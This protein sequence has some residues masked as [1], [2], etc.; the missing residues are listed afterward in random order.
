[1]IE[2]EVHLTEAVLSDLPLRQFDF[3]MPFVLRNL[4][5]FDLELCA[6][7]R[8][9]VVR[10]VLGFYRAAAR[11][12]V[13]AP[14]FG[15]AAV[16][17]QRL[18]SAL[19]TDVRFHILAFHGLFVEPEEPDDPD[20]QPEFQRHGNPADGDIER[21]LAT[22]RRRVLRLLAQRRGVQLGA[23]GLDQP[24]GEA[25]EL[26]ATLRGSVLDQE[27]SRRRS[28]GP[29]RARPLRQPRRLA[30]PFS[31]GITQ[32]VSHDIPSGVNQK[33]AHIFRPL[34][35]RCSVAPPRRIPQYAV[36]VAPCP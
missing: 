9:V 13:L 5:A 3:T 28:G 16:V 7:V 30:H 32:F 10:A 29:L 20:P 19:N 17:T 31:D 36:V 25:S 6:A 2:T 34:E 35:T 15:V 27:R 11:H 22:C 8:K 26:A 24:A 21:L 23:D 4:I 14:G 33:Y 12:R 18:G 1:M